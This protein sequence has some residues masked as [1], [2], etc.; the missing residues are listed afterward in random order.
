[1]LKY[2]TQQRGT[3]QNKKKKKGGEN[4]LV[5][6]MVTPGTKWSSS[7]TV[8]Y[9]GAAHSRAALLWAAWFEEPS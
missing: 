3:E 8:S 4:I 2:L 5:G 7:H 9:G 6:P 1:M